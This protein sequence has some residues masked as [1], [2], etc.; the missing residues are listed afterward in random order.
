MKSNNKA[1]AKRRMKING[2]PV[3]DA[4][5][6]VVLEITAQ[7]IRSGKAGQPA[8]CAAAQ[9]CYRQLHAKDV[10]VHMGRIYISDGK[11]WYRYLTPGSIR[12]E[13]IAYD[14]RSSFKPGDYK[15]NPLAPSH[16]GSDRHKNPAKSRNSK[17]WAPRAK[18]HIIEGVRVRATGYTNKTQA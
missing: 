7:D 9:A 8:A 1:T 2:L 12:S 16:R 18:P 4:S 14:R 3:Y 11:R 15:L 13:I 6:P 10:R 5:K 17:G